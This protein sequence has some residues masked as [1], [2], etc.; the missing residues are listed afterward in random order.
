[1]N[2]HTVP[3]SPSQHT[4]THTTTPNTTPTQHHTETDR[5]KTEKGR[6]KK[7]K[8]EREK[9]RREEEGVPDSSI[10]SLYLIKLLNSSYPEGSSGGNQQ[11]D[12]SICLS[13]PKPKY[14]EGFTRQ[15]LSMMF[16]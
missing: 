1:M 13:P 3:S 2:V 12:G 15:T 16:S 6:G 10:H 9:R 14:N 7:M 11:P 4:Q 5:E 8:E